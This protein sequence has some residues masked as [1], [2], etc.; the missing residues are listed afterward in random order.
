[1]PKLRIFCCRLSVGQACQLINDEAQKGFGGS[2][3]DFILDEQRRISGVSSDLYGEGDSWIWGGGYWVIIV[4]FF[5]STL[6]KGTWGR[7]DLLGLYFQVTVPHKGSQGENSIQEPGEGTE[8]K[9]I[10]ESWLLAC[11][12][13]TS[14][15]ACFSNSEP[16]VQKWRYPQ[17][18]SHMNRLS[19]EKMPYRH[20][21]GAV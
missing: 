16:S 3:S 19:M 13:P 10:E 6:T 15:S 8:V 20:A 21:R 4:G 9:V 18:A 14:C 12:L 5:F 2:G 17:W 7:R 11:L 1:M